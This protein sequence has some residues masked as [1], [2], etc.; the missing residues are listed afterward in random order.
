MKSPKVFISYSWDDS[1]HKAWV[2]KLA[3][4]LADAGIEVVLDQYALKLGNNLSHFMERAVQDVDKV[5]LILTP[6]YK[7]KAENRQGGVG[8]EFSMINQAWYQ[9][10][11]DNTKF[12]PILRSGNEE[13]SIPVF[14][15]AYIH[16]D[17]RNDAEFDERL[18][19]VVKAIYDIPAVQ[20]PPTGDRPDFAQ[21]TSTS[22][23][24]ERMNAAQE[25][26]QQNVQGR[27][28]KR[29]LRQLVAENELKKALEILL[30]EADNRSDDRLSETAI[31]LSSRNNQL[32]RDISLGIL[33]TE[34][35]N[36]TRNK[37]KA[38]VLEV[39]GELED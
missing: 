39:I 30:E 31:L 32:R 4:G 9:M 12:I 23:L 16:G 6:N 11:A 15:N 38:A 8:Y 34:Q 2:L 26:H 21:T 37:I 36:I 29:H 35:Q 22:R 7:L 27:S 18:E 19:E 20:A 13:D 14:V 10:Q 25:V 17:M 33:T 3:K 28:L 5:L 24:T 1:R